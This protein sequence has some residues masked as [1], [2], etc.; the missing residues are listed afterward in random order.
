MQASKKLPST[1]LLLVA[2]DI[3]PCPSAAIDPMS[4]LRLVLQRAK[5]LG[6]PVLFVLS[7]KGIGQVGWTCY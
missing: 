2:P 7:C 4:L 3:Q 5:Q 6:V 1:K